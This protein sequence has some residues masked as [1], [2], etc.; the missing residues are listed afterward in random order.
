[1]ATILWS[2][3]FVWSRFSSSV[4]FPSPSFTSSKAPSGDTICL[5]FFHRFILANECDLTIKPTFLDPGRRPPTTHSF[6]LLPSAIYLVT[7]ICLQSLPSLDYVIY[8][9][10]ITIN[11]VYNHY[12]HYHLPFSL[13]TIITTTITLI[14]TCKNLKRENVKTKTKPGKKGEK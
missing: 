5:Y 1:M 13:F 4:G 7:N 14:K 9:V 2:C 6:Q 8:L 12:H 3:S 11:T 10:T